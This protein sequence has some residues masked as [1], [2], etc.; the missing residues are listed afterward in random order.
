MNATF[1]IRRFGLNIY[2]EL[3]EKYKLILGFWAVIV[4][5]YLMIWGLTLLIGGNLGTTGRGTLVATLLQFYCGLIPFLLYKNEN[6]HV[7]GT[8]YGI[9]PASTLE[10]TLTVFFIATLLFPALTSVLML[11]LDS[12]LASMPTDGGF[13]GHIWKIIF[14]TSGFADNLFN[15]AP[16]PEKTFILDRLFNATPALF[17]NPYFGMLLGQSALI[18]MAMLFRTHKIGKTLLVICGVGFL[19]SVGATWSIVATVKHLDEAVLNSMDAEILANWIE[20]FVKTVMVFTCYILPVVFW[21]LTYF[22]I[23]RIQY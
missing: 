13:S 21:V 16:S 11:S 5:V 7:E 20:N 15:F 18:F 10:K 8:F 17:L 9:T 4:L 12:L 2:K 14:T 23:R 1:N 6:R 22:R 3:L 19:V